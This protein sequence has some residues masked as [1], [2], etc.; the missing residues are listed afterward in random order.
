MKILT[1]DIE[2]SPHLGF[3]F[4]LFNQNFSLQQIEEWTRMIC[5]AAKW[6]GNDEVMF[7]SDFHNGHRNSVLAAYELVNEA[8][9]LVTYNGDSF[10]NKHLNREFLLQELTPPAPYQSVDLYRVNKSRFRFG[11]TKLDH[12]GEQLG[13]GQKVKHAGFQLWIDCL[14]GDIDAWDKMREYNCE[15][16]VLTEKAFDRIEPWIMNM[17]HKGLYDEV[18]FSCRCGSVNLQKRGFHYTMIGKY[19]RYRCNDCGRWL[20]SSKAEF[21]VEVK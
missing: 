16:V 3:H 2:T 20:N 11:S 7:Y 1:L 9:V 12:F 5:F 18:E 6:H 21:R 10:D 4:G 17:P 19:Q 14:N 15:D 8:D 13:V